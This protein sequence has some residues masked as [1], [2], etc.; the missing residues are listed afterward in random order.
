M[1]KTKVII[2]FYPTQVWDIV[3]KADTGCTPGGG[4]NNMKVFY[5]AGLLFQSNIIAT[6]D[7]LGNHT[8]HTF[9][10]TFPSLNYLFI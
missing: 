1:Y 5:D 10:V 3:E 8:L 7:R 9:S 2:F 4:H 6:A